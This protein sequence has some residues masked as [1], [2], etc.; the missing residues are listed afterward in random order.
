MAGLRMIA[1]MYGGIVI[2]DKRFVW[3]YAR[4]EAVP[5]AEMKPGS[6]RWVASEIAKQTTPKQEEV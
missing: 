6:V 2:N 3:D 1:K 4:D 5:E